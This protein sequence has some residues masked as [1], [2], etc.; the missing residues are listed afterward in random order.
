MLILGIGNPLCGDDGVGSHVVELLAGCRL[1]PG[2][3]VAEAGLPGWGLPN[4]LEGWE[5]VFLVD[6]VDM[7]EVPGSWRCFRPQ[8]VKLWLQDDT[9]SLHQPDL[10]AGLAL[11][12]ALNLLPEQLYIYGVQ[13]ADSSPGLPLSSLV[14]ACLPKLVEQIVHDLGKMKNDTKAHPHC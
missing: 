10:A 12:Q 4:W 11:T 7:G 13:P 14:S 3:Q 8:D 1:P 9:V 5:V 6:A 2:V